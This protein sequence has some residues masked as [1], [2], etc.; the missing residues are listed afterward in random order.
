[1][2]EFDLT[3]GNREGEVPSTVFIS[4][5]VPTSEAKRSIHR[6]RVVEGQDGETFHRR[7]RGGRQRGRGDGNGPE[8][9]DRL[10]PVSLRVFRT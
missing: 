6:R 8:R 5:S 1:M 4:W 7:G 3:S 9:E 10:E 2:I